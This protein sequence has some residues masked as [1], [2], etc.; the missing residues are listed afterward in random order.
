MAVLH[1]TKDNFDE[2]IKEGVTLVDFWAA[3]CGPCRMLGPIIEELATK[4]DGQHKIAKVDVDAE[5]ELAARFG[6]MSI[7]TVL[8]F[9]DGAELD[10]KI[11]VHP[12]E[13]FTAML[14]KA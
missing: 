12:L 6:V 5:S 8:L 9:R 11:G 14:D 1:L 7:P 4:Y 3:W 10:K 2:T 13:E